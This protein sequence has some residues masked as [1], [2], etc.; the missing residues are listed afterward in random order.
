MERLFRP[1]RFEADPHS[2]SASEE[3]VHWHET[4][5]NFLSTIQQPELD[6]RKLLVNFI[7]P[8]IYQL[9][10]DCS[11]YKEI[12]ETLNKIYVKPKN[13]VF[14]RHLLATT[15][16]ESGQSVDQFLQKLRCLSKDCNFRAVSAEKHRDEAIRDAFITGLRSNVIRQRLLE[17]PTLD[18]KL[19]FDEARMLEHAQQ[20]SLVYDSPTYVPCG[21]TSNQ[22]EV[23]GSVAHSGAM[24]SPPELNVTAAT[25]TVCFFCGKYRHPRSKCPAREA[26]CNS[27]GKK[28]HY[29]NVCR[30]NPS[31][32]RTASAIH[33]V[34]SSIV[35]TSSTDLSQSI[36]Q[37]KVNGVPL[38]ALIDTG[39]CEN[40]LSTAIARKHDWP[41]EPSTSAISMASTHLSCITRGHV[42]ACIQYKNTTYDRVKLSLLNNLCADV[43]LGISFLSQHK[44]VVIPFNGHLPSFS[45]CSLTAAKV[46]AP[47]L[48]SNLT[49]NCVP[50]A[51]KS[52]RH[53]IEDSRFI[54]TE[55]QQ[56]LKQNII[57]PSN[58]P[59]RAQ[60]LV[61][62][63]ERHKKRMVID[64]SQTIN[65]YTY[66]DAYPLPRVDDLVEKVSRYTVFSTL[67]LQSAYHQI[68]I[69]EK[70]KPYTAFEACG[71][72]YQ[73]RRIPFGV[74]NGVACFQRTI[75][76]MIRDERLQ[77][78]YAYVDNVTVCG[79]DM[80]E[81]DR[82]LQKFLDAAKKRGIT[83]NDSK[84]VIAVN[85]VKLLGYEVSNGLIKPDPDRFQALRELAVPHDLSSQR[86]VVGMLAY[87]AHWIPNFSDKIHSVVHNRS[88]PIPENVKNAFFDL[89]DELE[90]A[91][92]FT[93][94]YTR[95][96]IV[97]TDA[98]D[99]AI[100]ATLNQDGRPVAFFSRTLSPSEQHHSAIEKEAC[101]IVEALRKWK[102]YLLGNHFT[103]VTDQR[104]VA[105][106]YDKQ[107]KG[108]VKNDKIQRWKLEL[109]CFH[110][111]IRYRPGDQNKPADTLSRN[112]CVSAMSNTDLQQLHNTLCHPGVTRMLHF[113]RSKNLPFSV[114]DVKDVIKRCETCAEL[115]P[116]FIKPTGR[117][118]KATQPFE[119]ISVDFKGPLPSTSHN[120]Y[121]FTMVDEYS[122]FPFAFACSD[123]SSST[124]IKCFNQLFSI[125]GMPAYIHSDRGAAFMS[126]EL[127]RFLHDRGVA[128]SR[129]TPYNPRG[130]GQVER[131]NGTLWK[132][133]T[134]ALRAQQLNISQWECVL[135]DA[136]HSV[137]SLLCT[138]TNETPHERLFNFNRKSTTGIS[139]P[140]WLSSPGPVL[141]K[142]TVRS[143]K[144]DPVME[145][146]ELLNCNPQYAHVRFPDGREDTV[147]LRYLAPKACIPDAS[148]QSE[149]NQRNCLVEEV[150]EHRPLSLL[151]APHSTNKLVPPPHPE[152]QIEDENS[153]SPEQVNLTEKCEQLIQAQQRVRPY[154]LRNREV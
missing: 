130:N 29:Q 104:S 27:C 136:L 56:L 78:T 34:I 99:I 68:P 37:V 134:L 41:V 33:P 86:R 89:K 70:E 53:S 57:E 74:T 80:E 79:H 46:D 72:L 40:Y 109:S 23:T 48:F 87:Y 67:D 31:T 25:S 100:A 151:P 118:I 114:T 113:V 138:A 9:V 127:Q 144:Y 81:H 49:P 110:Y 60:V 120:K 135:L 15:K 83:F 88:F 107:H 137:R 132:A 71:K 62:T 10:I 122:R 59:W 4:F 8:S 42:Y 93:V 143:S 112:H 105:F 108:K 47:S 106:M 6:K 17:K 94:D 154:N 26:T 95:P 65:R 101:A 14:S 50:I 148:L 30:S 45:V 147:S 128:T 145:E 73:F 115:K 98:S 43:I 24:D 5:E 38:N 12:I 91:A 146:V 35:A 126:D 153:E 149:T 21:A 140:T 1:E 11:S 97:E 32:K 102:H 85:T 133:I 61:T 13:E 117:L 123:M 28:G 96:L 129:T 90:R 141:L 84:S 2:P 150:H 75:D 51:T 52:R 82:N 76:N 39:S 3:W 7:S 64:Y 18:L 44:H 131:L 66:L 22:T 121:L 124:V 55:I 69:L 119:R 125:F 36:V 20:Q 58:S 77:D 92:I 103:L 152:S 142:R 54:Q 116:R 111:D 16:Q 139:L 19:A 63:N